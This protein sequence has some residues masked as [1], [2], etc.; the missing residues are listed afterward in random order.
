MRSE[1]PASNMIQ[2]LATGKYYYNMD[3]DLIEERLWN[4][5]Y[6]EP[7]QFLKDLKMIVK[8]CIVSGDRKEY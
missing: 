1:D 5:Y 3:L 6:S 4:G 2:E 8:D 7:K